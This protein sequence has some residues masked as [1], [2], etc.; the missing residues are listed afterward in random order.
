MRR[1]AR[2][3]GVEIPEVRTPNGSPRTRASDRVPNL[4]FDGPTST[5]APRPDPVKE[6]LPQ[7]H[8]S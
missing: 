6:P 2:W 1:V 3:F 7:S 4:N 8:D 5:P